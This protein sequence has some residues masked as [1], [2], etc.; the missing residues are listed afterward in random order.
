MTHSTSSSHKL[1]SR[2]MRPLA[3]SSS[4]GVSGY[5][6]SPL[7]FYA[8]FSGLPEHTKQQVHRLVSAT[9]EGDSTGNGRSSGG[10]PSALHVGS[11]QEGGLGL[12]PWPQHITARHARWAHHLVHHI[13]QLGPSCSTPP[14]VIAAGIMLIYCCVRFTALACVEGVRCLL[15]CLC[16]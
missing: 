13:S 7:L 14:W 15:A 3:P 10:V 11:P 16:E 4:V 1:K 6:L 2:M 5:A 8:E 9:V 12:P